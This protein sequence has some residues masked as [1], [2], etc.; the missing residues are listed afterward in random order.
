MQSWKADPRTEMWVNDHR[1]GRWIDAQK[2]WYLLGKMT[3]MDHGL[4]AQEEP[5]EGAL[6]FEQATMRVLKIAGRATGGHEHMHT[7]TEIPAKE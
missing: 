6:S 2:A 4:G 1:D 7:H 3:P 5:A